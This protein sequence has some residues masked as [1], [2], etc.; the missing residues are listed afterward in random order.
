MRAIVLTAT[1][2]PEQLQLTDLPRPRPEEGQAL[3]R[4]Q[5]IGVSF[6]ETQIRAGVLP[7]P[8]PL[9][10]VI[11]AEVA[12]EVV[13]VGAGVDEKLLGATLVGVTGGLGAYAEYV[14][15]PAALTCPVP[16]GVTPE[17]ALAAAAPGALALALLH[18]AALT[19][20]E[21]VLVEAGT[22]SVGAH[23]VRH[24]KEFGAGHVIAT[25]GSPAKRARAA[26][27]GADT[28][29][30]HGTPGW[31]DGLP[32]NVDVV[33]E[34]IG[35]TSAGQVLAHLTPGT[36]RMLY[37]GLLS[38][39][40]AAVTAADLMP[41][42]VTVTACSGAAWAGQVFGTHY[43]ELLAR[44]ASGRAEADIARTLPL[45]QAADAH[46]LLESRAVTGRVLLIP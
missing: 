23:L 1:G 26:E 22:S 28:V 12:G 29:L 8:L 32:E 2:G 18:K 13:E 33:F 37:Y 24:A 21:T 27:L 35:G 7:F 17:R 3:V 9:P 46:R 36:G 43:P 14:A 15:L 5:A 10:A 42:G 25:A 31:P 38:G 44:L 30:D 11:G 45:E 39:E 6:A 19:G 16:D 34:S 20:G 41:R 4:A 40:Q